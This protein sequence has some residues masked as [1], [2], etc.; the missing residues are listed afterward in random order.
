MAASRAFVALAARSLAPVEGVVSLTQWRALIVIS[1]EQQRTLGAVA[2]ALGVHPSTATRLV[3]RLV[4]AGLLVRRDHPDDRRYI[5]L[6][7]TFKGEQLVG[8]V[9]AARKRDIENILDKIDESHR[10]PI[11]MA[12]QEF[13][14]A[15][16]EP[17]TP[18]T[19]KQ[20]AGQ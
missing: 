20:R 1:V 13:A 17:P 16:M 2:S 18:P 9:N 7:L 11:A 10:H 3:D 4:A 5:S 8:K 15:A 12:L 19:G 6:A 14:A